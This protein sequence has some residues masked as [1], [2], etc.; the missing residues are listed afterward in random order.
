MCG[1]QHTP[2]GACK[3]GRFTFNRGVLHDIERKTLQ[4]LAILWLILCIY[5]NHALGNTNELLLALFLSCKNSLT[6]HM[7]REI[8]TF[9]A[10]SE[11]TFG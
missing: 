8:V 10:H 5:S 4:K 7:Q 6:A 11:V 1:K 2:K 9:F 3:I